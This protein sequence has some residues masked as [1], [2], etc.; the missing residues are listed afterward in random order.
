MAAVPSRLKVTAVCLSTVPARSAN[1]LIEPS[2]ACPLMARMASPSSAL[3]PGAR[4]RSDE[5]GIPAI[6]VIDLLDSIEIPFQLEVRAEQTDAGGAFVLEVSAADPIVADLNFSDHFDQQVIEVFP[7]LHE[8]QQR[9]VARPDR[10][11]I[12]AV[13]IRIVEILLLHTPGLFE[14]LTPLLARIDE[15]PEP[16]KIDGLGIQ[17]LCGIRDLEFTLAKIQQQFLAVGA[18][19]EIGQTRFHQIFPRDPRN[20]SDTDRRP[21][22]VRLRAV[23]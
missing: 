4:E 10:L 19:R 2:S 1:I 8:R 20:C 17:F 16:G 3:T 11:P 5:I 15:H 18:R 22:R 14:N 9:L 23:P 6:A 12:E 21:V 7:A 13:H